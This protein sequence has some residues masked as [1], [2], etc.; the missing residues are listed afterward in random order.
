MILKSAE[1]GST[2]VEID[3]RFTKDSVPILYHDEAL[4]LRLVQKSGL[5][6]KIENYTYDQLTTFVRLIK[7]EKIP[8]LREALNA[9]VFQTDLT[10]V[11]LDTKYIGSLAQV[12]AL[13][14]E[15]MQ[16]AA[17]RGRTLQIV[18]GLPAREQFFKF[19]Q[20]PDYL[21]TPS[22]CEL[23]LEDAQVANARVWA[24]RFTEGTQNDKV[25][26][27]HSQGRLAFSW[28][29][30]APEFVTKFINEGNFDGLL[31]NYPS[32]VAYNYYVQR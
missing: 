3:V 16:K 8:T 10:F 25:A 27:A 13:Q 9:V 19:L 32:I 22:L 1:F 4:N 23:T 30:D 18:I 31:S 14:Q 29:I 6:G 26:I 11:W 15:F 24:P 5:I 21:N 12:R 20:L 28:T 2:G 17:A 7:G